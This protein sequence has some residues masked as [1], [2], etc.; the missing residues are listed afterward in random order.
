MDGT[1]GFLLHE[2]LRRV[3]LTVARGNEYVDR[4]APWKLAKD[5]AQR[6]ALESVLATLVRQLIRQA[7]HLAPFM[8]ERAEE[9]W[10]QLGAPGSVHEQRF[11]SLAA[12]DPTGWHVIRGDPLFPKEQS[13]A[14]AAK[15]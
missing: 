5:P 8:P 6:A 10:R 15:S 12:L 3:W 2:A 14:T 13:A 1:R 11:A 4:P 7:V 9:L